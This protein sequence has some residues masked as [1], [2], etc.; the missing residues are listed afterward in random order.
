MASLDIFLSMSEELCG[1]PAYYLSG[2]GYADTY[3]DTVR[4]IAGE[5]SINRLFASYSDLP[6]CC[7]QDREAAIRANLLSH[8]EFGPVARNIVKLWYTATWFVLP[9]AWH[10][11]YNGAADD[12]AFVPDPYAYPEALLG[13]AVGAHPA[14]AKPTGHQAWI[15][16]PDYLPLAESKVPSECVVLATGS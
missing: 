13:P 2:T 12:R 7:T 1:I 14:G 11:K 4:K 9:Q 10:R 3:L 15:S 8:D 5:D 6:R 16:P